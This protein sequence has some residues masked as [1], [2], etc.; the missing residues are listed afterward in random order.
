MAADQRKKRMNAVNIVACSQDRNGSKKR[1]L[2]ITGYD[3]MMRCNVS[4]L[5]DE[6]K[7][8][9]VSKNDQIGISRRDFIPF[10]GSVPHH[11]NVLA[12]VFTVPQEIFEL[13]NLAEVLSYEVWQTCLSDNERSL[14]TEFLPKGTDPERL[15]HDL[16]AGDSFHFGNPSL[17][18][19]NFLCSGNLHPDNII[20]HRQSVKSHKK[21]YYLEL[22]KYHANMIENLQTWK[23]KWLSC[24]DSDEEIVE[25]IWSSK[26]LHGKRGHSLEL[27]GEENL[28]CTP[29]C[30][31]AAGDKGFSSDSPNPSMLQ[32]ESQRRKGIMDNQ[33]GNSLDWNKVTK[34]RRVDQLQKHNIQQTDGAKYMSYIK[35]SK[36]HYERVKNSMKHNSNSIQSRSLNNVL[37]NIK[38]LHVK[39]FEAYE[40]EERQKLHEHW[41]QLAKRDLPAHYAVWL[42]RQSCEWQLR[43]SLGHDLK[44]K[45]K[46]LHEDEM[47]E[48]SDVKSPEMT[49]NKAT[50]VEPTITTE[51]S[52]DDED[53][54]E[55]EDEEE[56]E[57]EEDTSDGLLLH[58][59]NKAGDHSSPP[60]LEDEDI[61]KPDCMVEEKIGYSTANIKDNSGSSSTSE[62][63]QKVQQIV[64]LGDTNQFNQLDPDP[65]DN[66]II[67]KLDEVS[68]SVSEYSERLNNKDAPLNQGGPLASADHVWPVANMPG[69]FSSTPMDNEYSASEELPLSHPQ[70]MDGQAAHLVNLDVHSSENDVGKARLHRQSNSVSFFN[71]Y[72]HD[73]NELFQPFLKSN[74]GSVH[75]ET[76]QSS[77][78]FQSGDNLMVE[79][80]QF[81][82][83][84]KEQVHAPLPLVLKHTGLNDLY[85]HQNVHGNEYTDGGTYSFPRQENLHVGG[86][87]DWDM[88]AVRM[89]APQSH[90]NGGDL[91][92]SW[93]SGENRAHGGWSGL[94]SGVGPSQG[95]RSG[96]ASDQSLFSVLT[97]CNELCRGSSYDTVVGSTERF[98]QSGNYDE[99]GVRIPSASNTQQATNPLAYLSSSHEGSGGPTNNMGW[100]NVANQNSGL[101]D[102]LGKPFLK[103]WNQ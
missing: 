82:G 65:S 84:F 18:W 56:E 76:K 41:L 1:K 6:K 11:H 67:K 85:M 75:N 26:K 25:M 103:S 42:K 20:S 79:S 60:V 71:S 38:T 73:R 31:W 12:D 83:H 81:S 54:D 35:V 62:H 21:A 40:E 5:W 102:S 95:I 58:Q 32:G 50:E 28:V 4:L 24:K 37:G 94:E 9:V 93:F 70:V 30:S 57:E 66:E 46:S 29:E 49:D 39:P 88:N 59:T 64:S 2:G 63:D 101:Q 8:C 43:E 61:D 97:E 72:S 100:V 19:S 27:E 44:E 47:K 80:G 13:D 90:L 89:P 78:A 3:L 10:S 53:E 16:L 92:Q 52:D 86:M 69:P 17:K 96:N 74:A 14:L 15:V 23:D 99:M 87:Q 33:F 55:D 98:M 22:Q 48:N 77:L 51:S 34:T 36:E 68:S 7:K 91:G 45:L